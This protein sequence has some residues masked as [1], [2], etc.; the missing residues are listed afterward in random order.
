MHS[1]KRI[2]KGRAIVSVFLCVLLLFSSVPIVNALEN[3][4]E[5]QTSQTMTEVQAQELRETIENDEGDYLEDKV[6]VVYEDGA[7]EEISSQ[8][9]STL[10][11]SESDIISESLGDDGVA[12]CIE[13]SDDTTVADAVVEASMQPG[14]AYAQPVYVYYPTT[15]YVDDPV[16]AE[17]DV[18]A[19]ANQWW[20]YSLDIFEAWDYAKVEGS[21]EIAVLDT[22]IN[23]D[24]Q[25]L[26]NVIDRSNAYDVY[27][28]TPLTQSV[29]SSSYSHGVYVA[30]IAAAEANN[31]LGIAGVSYNA[32]ILPISVF[33]YSYYY[34]VVTDDTVLISA[35]EYIFDLIDQGLVDNLRVINM[36]LGGYGSYNSAFRSIIQKAEND[37]GILTVAA[38]GNGDDY[39]NPLTTASYPSDYEEVVSVVALNSEDERASWCD[40]NENKNIAAP[41]V[42]IYS[43]YYNGTA[44]YATASGTSMSTPMVSG[45]AALL[46]SANPDLSP[47]DVRDALYGTAID[48][49]DE[50]R[51]NYY[52]WGK[53]NP[54]EAVKAVV[55]AEISSENGSHSVYRTE[56]L[57]LSASL[58]NE[59]IEV[60]AWEWSS[61]DERIATVDQN[62]LVTGITAGSAAITV[63][64]S[65]DSDIKGT[66]TVTVEEIQLT[67]TPTASSTVGTGIQI[68]WEAAQVATSYQIYRRLASSSEASELID[69]VYADSSISYSYLDTTAEA[70]TVYAYSITPVAESGELVAIGSRSTECFGMYRAA[71]TEI[72]GDDRYK[73]S[74]LISSMFAFESQISGNRISTIILACGSNYP[75]ALAA[76]GLSGV[77]GAP[78]I[79]TPSDSVNWEV[80]EQIMNYDPATILVLGGESAISQNVLDEIHNMFPAIDIQRI[81]DDD[82]QGTAEKI[83]DY[84]VGSWGTTAIVVAGYNYPDALSVSSYAYAT[85]SPIFLTE[86]D[87]S[88]SIIARHRIASGGFD[89][90]IIIGGTSA[91]G[92][93]VESQLSEIGISY[94]RWYG[95]NRYQTSADIALHAIEE[96][97]LSLDGLGFATGRNFADAL[98]SSYLLGSEGSVLLLADEGV[99]GGL[100]AVDALVSSDAGIKMITFF[101]GTSVLPDSLKSLIATRAGL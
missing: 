8:L 52:G 72:Y 9:M 58:I 80:T 69:T 10:E 49:G 25:D 7:Y 33:Y 18:S 92:E 59:E 98:S 46:F 42:S 22:G 36:S 11:A 83:Y 94:E 6:L 62:G 26:A 89:R 99:S 79:L 84:S 31:G 67:S 27:S 95:D 57:Q 88:I 82:R 50:G 100:D 17:S 63:T 13:I 15:T 21:V 96:G 24:H 39:G 77:L 64:A 61:S 14:V 1:S 65:N 37:Y 66:F 5:S 45:I 54:V 19:Q 34:G 28:Q 20:L 29:S 73:T 70:A 68:T 23:F 43:T 81:Y 78:L 71:I 51:D 40:Y 91:V 48:L 76:S 74:A 56:T 53:I 38:G 3:K 85:K 55:G 12:V 60:S 2:K 47:S 93:L 35:Y 44:S 101:G 97:V 32:T 4:D 87:G 90:V 86:S 75:D 30:G 16:A 41:G